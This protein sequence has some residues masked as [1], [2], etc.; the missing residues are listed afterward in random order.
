M[1]NEIIRYS[2]IFLLLIVFIVQLSV[3]TD[4]NILS[5]KLLAWGF[6]RG[7][8]HEQSVLDSE[9]YRVIKD[10]GGIAIGSKDSNKVYLTFDCGYEAG[11]TEKILD[12][13]KDKNVKGTFFITGHYLNSASDIVK[14][15]IEEGHIVG[16]Q[17]PTI[18]MYI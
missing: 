3:S 13:L 2:F 17:F 8:N 14:R 16:N 5:N 9:S 6:T 1:R 15:M 11:F 7:K 12:V 10:Y 18:L 4:A